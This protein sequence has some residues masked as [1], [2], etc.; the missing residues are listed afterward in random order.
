MRATNLNIN[1]F[2]LVELMIVV[3]II[4]ILGAIAIPAYQGYVT[5]GKQQS[6]RAVLEQFP[7]VLETY[8]AENGRMCPACN[9]N[10]AHTYSYSENDS[11]AEDTAGNK[12]TD[13]YKDF[14]G[15][16]TTSQPSLYDY[17]VT[18]TVA[19]CPACTE[20]AQSTATPVAS[21]GAPAGNIVSAPFQ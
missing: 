21:R 15:K 5:S 6:A 17:A 1:G 18:I 20:S 8:R 13:F 3:A 14:K 12:V 19:G 2:T 7:I 9:A 10:G 16:A 11:G 4:A